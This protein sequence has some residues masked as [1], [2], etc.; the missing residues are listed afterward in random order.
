MF[1]KTC[2]P[3]MAGQGGGVV[4][5]SRKR[6]RWGQRKTS[7]THHCGI[8]RHNITSTDMVSGTVRICRRMTRMDTSNK[9]SRNHGLGVAARDYAPGITSRNDT[10]WISAAVLRVPIRNCD[11]SAHVAASG[12]MVVVTRRIVRAAETIP[13]ACGHTKAGVVI[14]CVV[15]LAIADL[16]SGLVAVIVV[17]EAHIAGRGIGLDRDWR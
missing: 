6:T 3:M 17:V 4:K 8:D 11:C 13:A 12:S 14:L 2:E 7:G 15:A 9:P 16:D 10:T 5:G 1:K